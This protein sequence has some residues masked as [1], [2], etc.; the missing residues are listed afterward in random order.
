MEMSSTAKAYIPE[1]P[2]A[3]QKLVDHAADCL[4][5]A[6]VMFRHFIQVDESRDRGKIPEIVGYLNQMA[7]AL[8]CLAVTEEG[9]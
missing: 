7:E 8:E 2:T 5:G 3:A 6:S 9:S 4:T 1:P